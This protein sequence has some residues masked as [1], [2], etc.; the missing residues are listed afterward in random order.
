MDDA[1]PPPL[2][3]SVMPTDSNGRRHQAFPV[4][5]QTEVE[6]MRR[7]GTVV[8]FLHGERLYTAGET[9]GP[10]CIADTSAAATTQK[11]STPLNTTQPPVM[12]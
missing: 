2:T 6:R 10:A 9:S 3:Q 1:L 11:T 4:L 7:F 8:H 12:R 5:A